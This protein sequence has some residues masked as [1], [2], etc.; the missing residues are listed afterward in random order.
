[1]DL[2]TKSNMKIQIRQT[3]VAKFTTIDGMGI[4]VLEIKSFNTPIEKLKEDKIR[5]AEISKKMLRK[6]AL[7]AKSV[8]DLITFALMITGEC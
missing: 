1:M 2:Y 6:R 3:T 5:F 8:K 4:G 7:A